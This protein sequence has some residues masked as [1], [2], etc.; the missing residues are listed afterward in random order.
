MFQMM[1]VFAEFERS[2]IR[3]RVLAGLARAREEGT[4]LGRRAASRIPTPGRL[5]RS[6]RS[7][8]PVPAFAG[9]LA[10]LASEWGP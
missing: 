9:F 5:R 1:G 2:M 8:P 6:G 4:Q 10:N 7:A 3:E